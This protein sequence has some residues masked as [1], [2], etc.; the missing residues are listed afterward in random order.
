MLI[1]FGGAGCFSVVFMKILAMKVQ[2]FDARAKVLTD[3]L[4]LNR[5]QNQTSTPK[6]DQTT[7][8]SITP[9]ENNSLL[10]NQDKM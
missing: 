3:P 9:V 2:S 8:P 1:I 6:Y 7:H 4:L 10:L 5:S